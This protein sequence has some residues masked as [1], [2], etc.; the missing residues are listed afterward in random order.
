MCILESKMRLMFELRTVHIRNLQMVVTTKTV[1]NF[2]HAAETHNSSQ[3]FQKQCFL[4]F[5]SRYM[6]GIC[7]N[8][9][10][11]F[12]NLFL[13]SF[14]GIDLLLQ[15][16][17]SFFVLATK[18]KTKV[19]NSC[20]HGQTLT[21]KLGVILTFLYLKLWDDYTIGWQEIDCLRCSQILYAYLGKG[22]LIPPTNI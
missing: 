21:S 5:L 19:L 2:A 12:Q 14:W 1:T 15:V 8:S 20:I 22:T 10:V 11:C 3:K 13:M 9:H 17:N 7:L 16:W 4:C 18:M 6:F